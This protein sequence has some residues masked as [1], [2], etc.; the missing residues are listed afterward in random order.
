MFPHQLRP[1]SKHNKANYDRH[2]IEPSTIDCCA[3][4]QYSSLFGT[5]ALDGDALDNSGATKMPP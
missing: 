4:L 3:W 2:N 1:E 5:F